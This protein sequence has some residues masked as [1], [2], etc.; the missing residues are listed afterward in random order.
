MADYYPILARAVSRLA[1]NNAP[2]RQE[3]YEHARKVLAAQLRRHD[4][5]FSTPETISERIAFETATLRLEAEMRSLGEKTHETFADHAPF[6]NAND[7]PDIGSLLS[8]PKHFW[9]APNKLLTPLGQLSVRVAKLQQFEFVSNRIA[10]TER[11]QF[12]V[13]N[14]GPDLR[15]LLGTERKSGPCSRGRER[16]RSTM[17]PN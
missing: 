16:P 7:K 15:G 1:T 3:L 12:I 8:Q 6:C 11:P 9:P 17:P 2:A 4:P 5:Q 14:V 13:R 10:S